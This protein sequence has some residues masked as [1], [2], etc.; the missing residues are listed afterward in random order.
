MKGETV[1]AIRHSPL[2]FLLLWVIF[3]IYVGIPDIYKILGGTFGLFLLYPILV[4]MHYRFAEYRKLVWIFVLTI[5]GLIIANYSYYYFLNSMTKSSKL[6]YIVITAIPISWV[7]TGYLLGIEVFIE[8]N[9]FKNNIIIRNFRL[10]CLTIMLVPFYCAIPLLIEL[11]KIAK[12]ELYGMQSLLGGLITSGLVLLIGTGKITL[13]EM[14][15][16]SVP[17]NG[18]NFTIKKAKKFALIGIAAILLLSTYWEI[19]RGEWL[20]WAE[21]AT[22]FILYVFLQFRFTRIICASQ[23]ELNAPSKYNF[24]SLKDKKSIILG[25]ALLMLFLTLIISVIFF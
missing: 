21:T 18:T 7:I 10:Y 24:P 2:V 1:T 11:G 15:Y 16:V 12:L 17:I 8:P 22:V 25:L 20:V 9:A 5:V 4:F 23:K 3:L 13:E 19:Y 6:L 14:K